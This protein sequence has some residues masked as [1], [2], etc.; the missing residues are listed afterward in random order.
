MDPADSADGVVVPPGSHPADC[1]FQNLHVERTGTDGRTVAVSFEST[2]AHNSLNPRFIREFRAVATSLHGVDA[3]CVVVRG[4][5]GV[6][7]SGADLSSLSGDETDADRLRALA[8]DLH[9]GI[10]ALLSGPAPVVVGV[11]GVA[12]GAGFGLALAGDVVIASEDAR[13]EYVYPRVGLTGDGAVT[14]LL[15]RLVG[16]REAQRIALLDRPV[17]AA[18]AADVG[19]VTET[20]PADEFEERLAGVVSRLADGP[21]A[22]YARTRRLLFSSFDRSLESHLAAEADAMAAAART[23]DY[24]RGHAAFFGDRDPAFEGR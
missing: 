6:F 9:A 21:T 22:A 18:E 5:P 2:S 24:R 3:R 11:E 15:P 13:F 10:A 20:V 14:F 8:T 19:L 17:D 12:A 23:D 1:E 4:A 16:L 7:C